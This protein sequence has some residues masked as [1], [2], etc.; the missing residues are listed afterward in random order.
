MT[1]IATK[2]D[3]TMAKKEMSVLS[4]ILILA[5]LILTQNIPHSE[6][7][8]SLDMWLTNKRP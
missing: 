2:A 4:M 8:D 5:Y 6:D 3:T 7:T 1:I